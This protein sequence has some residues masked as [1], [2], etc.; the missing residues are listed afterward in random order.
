MFSYDGIKSEIRYRT[1]RSSGAGGQHVNKVETRV[2]AIF[3]VKSSSFLTE[4]QKAFIQTKIGTRISKEGE[5]IIA[6]S[7]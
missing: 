7:D 6:A 4:E 2:E 1:S 5:L 3:N